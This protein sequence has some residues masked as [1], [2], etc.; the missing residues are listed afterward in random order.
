MFE[1]GAEGLA[2]ATSRPT[3][4]YMCPLCL[5][6]FDD[7]NDLTR[8]HAPPRRL[9]GSVVALS[10]KRC[11]HDAGRHIDVQVRAQEDYL[12]LLDGRME[13]MRDAR[14]EV[15]GVSVRAEAGLS[16]DGLRF[17]P[18][19]KRNNPAQFEAHRAAWDALGS[20]GGNVKFSVVFNYRRTVVAAGWLRSAYLV[21]FAALG[22]TY[23]LNPRLDIVRRQIHNP[24]DEILKDIYSHIAGA[25]PSARL[26]IRVEDPP[27]LASLSVEM[28]RHLVLLPAVDPSVDTYASIEKHGVPDLLQVTGKGVDWPVDFP[29]KLDFGWIAI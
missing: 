11:N 2:V 25:D 21:A 19:M 9:G 26:I 1:R 10:C 27:E 24:K 23:I 29:L 12:D 14:L 22:Y 13:G 28:G 8:E 6:I 16:P 17:I 18:S 7:P 5:Q 4:G 3:A 20:G 15:G